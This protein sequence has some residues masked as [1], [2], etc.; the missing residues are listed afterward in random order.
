MKQD[1]VLSVGIIYKVESADR[2]K[3]YYGSTK[4]FENRMRKHKSGLKSLMKG[5]LQTKVTIYEIIKDQGYVASIVEEHKNIKRSDLEKIEGDYIENNNNCINKTT[6][7]YQK[8]HKKK[9][10]QI[11]FNCC[12]CQ[13]T[14]TTTHKN[15]HN[16]TKKHCQALTKQIKELK[17]TFHKVLQEL[18][19]KQN[20][21]NPMRRHSQNNVTNP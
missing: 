2:S 21:I 17:E 5:I 20:V 4:N 10:N 9:Y 11:K 13:G 18:S 12:I 19:Q 3:V 1:E 7:G 6:P 8:I 16:N 15:I 14:Y